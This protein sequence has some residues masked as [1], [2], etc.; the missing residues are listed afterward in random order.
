MSTG[1]A[2]RDSG[3]A[4]VLAADCSVTW[5]PIPGWEEFYEVSDDGRVRSS[6][7]YVSIGN[8]GARRVFKAGP[9]ATC[10]APNGYINVLLQRAGRSRSAGVHRLMAEAF[11]GPAPGRWHHARHLDGDRTNN[12]LANI[13]WGSPRDNAMDTIRHGRHPK[14]AMTHCKRGHE[15][16]AENTRV[17]A[18]GHRTCLTCETARSKARWAREKAAR[19]LATAT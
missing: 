5:K 4:D 17:S 1:P 18:R 11:Y 14:A 12:V 9:V 19:Q 15:F 7:D 16:T 10:V 8:G 2:L 13:A 3:V 6:S